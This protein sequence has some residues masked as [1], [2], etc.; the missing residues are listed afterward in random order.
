MPLT[1]PTDAGKYVE[2]D[3]HILKEAQREEGIFLTRL[4]RSL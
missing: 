3:D 4:V 1:P 2:L